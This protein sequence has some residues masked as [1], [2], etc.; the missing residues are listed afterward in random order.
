M[1]GIK[2]Y[3]ILMLYIITY[4]FTEE[5]SDFEKYKIK[6]CGNLIKSSS[7]RCALINN[8]C[9]EVGYQYS[10]YLN[11][12][13]DIEIRKEICEN[14][15]TDYRSTIKFVFNNNKCIEVYRTCNEIEEY[16][17]INIFEFL[18]LGG[19]NNYY[20]IK[21]KDQFYNESQNC[22][23]A[24]TEESC[25]SIVLTDYT[26]SKCIWKN[27]SC[28][29]KKIEKCSDFYNI[30]HPTYCENLWS[31]NS[32][33]NCLYINNECKDV[34]INC[35]LYTGNDPNECEA[36]L[37]KNKPHM[38][39]VFKNNVCIEELKTSCSDYNNS[40]YYDYLYE[41][42]RCEPIILDETNKYCLLLNNSCI[43]QYKKCE[44]YKG[45]NK[46]ECES[47]FPSNRSDI[48]LFINN[49]CIQK[50]KILVLNI[51]LKKINMIAL[52]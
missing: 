50:K 10:N 29:L 4:I 22:E 28:I 33:T 45:N 17:T 41:E 36:I 7:N 43:E 31:R 6:L 34:Y 19:N 47:I 38:K 27:T 21:G 15:Q 20:C 14:L 11:N 12:I 26:N 13:T 49:E 1:K 40:Y 25:K 52:I 3:I 35:S 39:C 32:N 44:N 51:G 18:I 16:P 42:N 46:T 24:K 5:C 9:I 37:L 48:C 2:I 30:L 23:G 8:E